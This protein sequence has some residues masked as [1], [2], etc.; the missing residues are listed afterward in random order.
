MKRDLLLSAQLVL[1]EIVT[2]QGQLSKEIETTGA[3]I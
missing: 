1:E 2:I 3:E